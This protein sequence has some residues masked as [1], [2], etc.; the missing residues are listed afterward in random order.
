MS[1]EEVTLSPVGQY[2]RIS[3]PPWIEVGLSFSCS[4]QLPKMSILGIQA[5]ETQSI[6]V[7][8]GCYTAQGQ[9]WLDWTKS[10][11]KSGLL[12]SKQKRNDEVELEKA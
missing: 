9:K 4:K 10:G 1:T 5:K 12:D 11:L 6:L 8:W 7:S 2:R 3:Q